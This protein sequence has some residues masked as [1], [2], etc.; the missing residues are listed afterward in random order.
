[1]TAA[2]AATL[3]NLSRIATHTRLYVQVGVIPDTTL[4]GTSIARLLSVCTLNDVL[5]L[6]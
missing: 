5:H 6:V 1:M 4:P 2:A 3:H